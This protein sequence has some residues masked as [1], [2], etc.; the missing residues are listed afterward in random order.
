M[1]EDDEVLEADDGN[2]ADLREETKE[3]Y[4]CP[5]CGR[6]SSA[7]FNCC[8]AQAVRIA[9]VGMVFS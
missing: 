5:K 7:S 1:P 6:C 9:L 4:T 8:N 2:F 3:E